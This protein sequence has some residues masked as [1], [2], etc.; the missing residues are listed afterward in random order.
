MTTTTTKTAKPVK[1]TDKELAILKAVLGL[2]GGS[3]QKFI[4]HNAVYQDVQDLALQGYKLQGYR[5]TV[6]LTA[7]A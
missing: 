3:I 1:A 2:A 7:G 6:P 5:A 4:R